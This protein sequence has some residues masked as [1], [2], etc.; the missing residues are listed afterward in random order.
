MIDI[1]H[2]L[3]V[4]Q[5]YKLRFDNNITVL[6]TE[7]KE[8]YDDWLEFLF[9][10]V[11]DTLLEKRYL[12]TV[13]SMRCHRV[14]YLTTLV[15]AIY[16]IAFESVGTSRDENELVNPGIYTTEHL[17]WDY[18]YGFESKVKNNLYHI[19]DRLIFTV[20][21]PLHEF[22][23]GAAQNGVTFTD[24][25]FNHVN[26]GDSIIVTCVT[27]IEVLKIHDPHLY[28]RLSLLASF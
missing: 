13:N 24:F 11:C 21:H 9:D 4:R 17:M 22:V 18:L 10:D 15:N 3:P 14:E 19:A 20:F 25:Q 28:D 2:L 1:S 5:Q 6:A 12:I 8:F 16:E 27:N 26:H 7:Y 23:V